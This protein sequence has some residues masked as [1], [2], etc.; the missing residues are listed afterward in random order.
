MARS[1]QDPAHKALRAFGTLPPCCASDLIWRGSQYAKVVVGYAVR[2][3]TLIFSVGLSGDKAEARTGY[4]S[5]YS[6]PGAYTASGQVM[7]A[8]TWGVAN[9]T[10]PFG[11]ELTVCYAGRCAYDVPVIDRGPYVYGREL[12]LTA[13][14][15]DRIGL[16]YA[17][18]GLVTWW[19]E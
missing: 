14:V 10:L 15:A 11:T 2:A 19:V 13:A 4:A 16:T 6:I 12:D 7:T 9:R 3:H 8:S 17:G 1:V 5:W 18:V